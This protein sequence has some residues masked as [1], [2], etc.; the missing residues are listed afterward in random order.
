MFKSEKNIEDFKIIMYAIILRT[1]RKVSEIKKKSRPFFLKQAKGPLCYF[2]MKF[3]G[4][5][6][7]VYNGVQLYCFSR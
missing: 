7:I 3:T 2:L 5:K 4:I 6:M 1:H